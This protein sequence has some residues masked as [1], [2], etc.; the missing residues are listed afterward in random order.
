[1]N[2]RQERPQGRRGVRL[3]EQLIHPAVAQ[4]VQVIDRV[5]PGDHPGHDRGDLPGRVAADRGVQPDPL[6]NQVGQPGLL[7]QPHHRDQ[8]GQRHDI[9]SIERG[10]RVGGAV[11]QSHLRGALS[12]G[13][14]KLQQLP[15]SQVRGHFPCHDTINYRDSS[16][17]PG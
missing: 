17:D 10:A 12:L 6:G 9:L 4:H 7:G 11:Q 2:S 5:R 3:P 13:L 1:M 16:V 15:S 8:P 14:W